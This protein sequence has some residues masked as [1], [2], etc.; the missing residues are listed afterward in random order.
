M[1]L[2]IMVSIHFQLSTATSEIDFASIA[3]NTSGL[4]VTGFQPMMILC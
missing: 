4:W 2:T 1:I 3:S